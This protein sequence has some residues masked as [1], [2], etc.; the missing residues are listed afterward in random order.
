MPEV[1]DRPHDA[2]T[3]YS[4]THMGS[5][6]SFMCGLY[7]TVCDIQPDGSRRFRDQYNRM[8]VFDEKVWKAQG[9]QIVTAK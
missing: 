2:A 7:G 3:P 8:Q 4:N 1:L 9:G 6:V 5:N